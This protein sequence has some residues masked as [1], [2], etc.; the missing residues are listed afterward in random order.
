MDSF[1]GKIKRKKYTEIGVHSG[2]ISENRLDDFK[3]ADPTLKNEN[4]VH[5]E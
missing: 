1:S 2:N 3:S 4:R 5:Y